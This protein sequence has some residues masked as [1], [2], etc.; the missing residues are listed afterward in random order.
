[1]K[2]NGENSL[3]LSCENYRVD[4][5][6]GSWHKSLASKALNF[7]VYVCVHFCFVFWLF[8]ICFRV[9][10]DCNQVKSTF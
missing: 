4:E 3:N 9:D 7:S 5:Q 2:V 1:M 8:V 6:V 10:S